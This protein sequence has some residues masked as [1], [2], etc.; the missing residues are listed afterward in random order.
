MEGAHKRGNRAKIFKTERRA[1]GIPAIRTNPY[2]TRAS[3]RL[4]TY[5]IF[6]F[7]NLGT[8]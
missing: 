7:E 5:R 6:L 1:V 2:L 4:G 8:R 3:V